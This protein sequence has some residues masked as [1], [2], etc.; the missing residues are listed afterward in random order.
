MMTDA[1]STIL[2][3]GLVAAYRATCYRVFGKPPFELAV[4][5][6]SAPLA[7]L[8]QETGASGAAFVTAWNP[9]GEELAL[10]VNRRRH[11]ALRDELLRVRGLHL[12]E[13]FGAHAD[14]PERGEESLLVLGL[15]R[16]AACALGRR[17]EQNAVLWSDRDAVPRLVLLR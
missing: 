1:F 16:D 10:E 13:G 6:H 2:S 11:D 9:L 3:P 8:L 17:L 14:D 15:D 4:D 12:V 7:A 5:R